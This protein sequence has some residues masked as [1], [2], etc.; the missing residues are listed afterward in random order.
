MSHAA[1]MASTAN[2]E[3][4]LPMGVVSRQHSGGPKKMF[5]FRYKMFWKSRHI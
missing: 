4:N 3:S 1:P 2:V 5:G